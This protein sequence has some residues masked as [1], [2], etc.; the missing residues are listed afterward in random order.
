M[1]R[2]LFWDIDGTLLSTGRAGVFALEEAAREICGGEVDLASM[3]TSGL[4]DG[5]I[6]RAVMEDC[7]ADTADGQVERFLE[8][9]ER[10]LPERLH[11]RQ[12][13]V[14]AGVETIL[15]HLEGRDD[16]LNLLLTGNTAAG[17]KAKL[18]HYG[19]AGRFA[20]GA[21]CAGYERRDSIARRA[22]QSVT[23]HG[24]DP[25]RDELYVIGDTPHDVSCGKAIEAITV[26]VASGTYSAEE[27]AESE[28]SL[29]LEEL[30]EPDRF[31]ELVLGLARPR[32]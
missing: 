3:K 12:G 8:A 10:H 15:D 26:A 1:K 5:E 22:R 18:T 14:L 28:P 11:W 2:V 17:A 23:E 9:Y 25:E 30:P 16:V 7:G 31:E 21:F 32:A 29:V 19:L 24:A 4:T 6:A 13:E 20:G 27:L